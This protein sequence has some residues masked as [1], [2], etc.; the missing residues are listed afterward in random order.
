MLDNSHPVTQ[1]SVDFEAEWDRQDGKKDHIA[2]EDDED[3]QSN[4][5]HKSEYLAGIKAERELGEEIDLLI[6]GPIT[7]D[8]GP[9]WIED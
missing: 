9:E 2:P 7:E 6:N 8:E 1:N 5:E 4:L 3:S